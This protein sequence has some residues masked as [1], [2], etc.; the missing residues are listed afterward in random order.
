MFM[1]VNSKW[2]GKPFQRIFEV[3]DENDYYEH[4]FMWSSI[5]ANYPA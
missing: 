4:I 3:L 5:P 1:K 2:N